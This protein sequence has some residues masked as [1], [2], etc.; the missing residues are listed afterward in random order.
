LNSVY[1]AV[2]IAIE[3]MYECSMTVM[4][5]VRYIVIKIVENTGNAAYY[6]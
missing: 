5:N 1:V 4:Y 2:L 3:P 6:D